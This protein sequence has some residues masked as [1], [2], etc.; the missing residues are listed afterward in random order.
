STELMSSTLFG[1]KK[2][3]FTGAIADTIGKVQGAESG[4]LFLD[5]VGDLVSDTQARLL[6]F[7]NDRSYERL[8]EPRER[9][10]NVRL[11]AATTRPIEEEVRAGRFREDLFFRLN[12]VSL[13]LPPLRE[14]REDALPLAQ[15]YLRFFG[16]NRREEPLSFS[17]AAE[18]AI[19]SYEWPGNLRE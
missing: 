10:A 16:K 5:E 9:K 1:H 11:I 3:A 12:V 19:V 2:G 13:T 17:V 8:G 7:L 4:T 15:H 18:Q 14:R 6:R